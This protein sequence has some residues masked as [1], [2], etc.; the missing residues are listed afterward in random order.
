MPIH[1]PS[2]T[3]AQ[4]NRPGFRNASKTGLQPHM[5]CDC[6]MPVLTDLSWF[7]ALTMT[8]GRGGGFA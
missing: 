3:A 7:A 6:A 1:N 8:K 2:F 5:L 4:S